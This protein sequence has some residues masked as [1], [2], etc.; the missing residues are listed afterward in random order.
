MIFF[1]LP[2]PKFKLEKADSSEL[3]LMQLK[4][5]A[6][7]GEVNLNKIGTV[8]YF[9]CMVARARLLTSFHQYLAPKK[10]NLIFCTE[11]LE[12][13]FH[14]DNRILMTAMLVF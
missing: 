13:V 3:S 7:N 1:F 12:E 4:P 11:V 10:K 5:N 14:C 9:T 6:R 2:H 8:L